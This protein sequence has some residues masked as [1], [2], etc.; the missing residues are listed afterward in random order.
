METIWRTVLIVTVADGLIMSQVGERIQEQ[1]CLI[2]RRRTDTMSGKIALNGFGRLGRLA[3]MAQTATL[4]SQKA[5][6]V[7]K[8][9][10]NSLKEVVAD[11]DR[12]SDSL[13]ICP[14]ADIREFSLKPPDPI[15]TDALVDMLGLPNSRYYDRTFPKDYAKKKKAKRRQQKQARR[16]NR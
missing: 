7:F 5:D 8:Q 1:V 14:T 11:T 9:G 6:R 2:K 3:L 10:L 4:I 15:V 16:K 13:R 12:R